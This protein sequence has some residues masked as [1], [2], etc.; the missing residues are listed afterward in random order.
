MQKRIYIVFLGMIAA[1]P[2]L[3][4]DM[5]LPAIPRIGGQWGV[6]QS[7][8]N[9]SLVL[10]FVAYSPTLLV[11]GSLSDRYGRRPILLSG[12]GAFVVSSLLCAMSGDVYQLIVARIFQGIAAAGASSMVM[13]IARDYFEG[14]ER[15]KVLAWIGIILGLAPMIAPSIGSAILKHGN[16]RIIFAV[17]AILATVSLSLTLA[18]YRETALVLDKDGPGSFFKRYARLSR[19]TR[20]VLANGTTGLLSAPFLG[21]VAF[22]ASA[23]IVHF[24]MSEQRFAILFGANAVFAIM[25]SAACTRVIRRYNEYRLITVT[26][27]GCLAAGTVL[28]ITGQAVWILFTLAMGV[29]SFF[30]GMS[31]PLINHLVLEQVDRDIGAA[32]SGIV[33]YQFIAGAC[34]MAIATYEWQ[35]PF[36]VFGVM[37]TVCPLVVLLTWPLLL[38]RIRRRPEDH[39]IDIESQEAGTKE[40]SA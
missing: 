34:G 30:F 4:T 15:Q 40:M 16:W 17:Q 18:I 38:K 7:T 14:K 23:Y 33:C 35:R 37:A 28:L 29:Y 2:P 6:A 21:F 32:A 19:N 20:Y 10:W 5:Y 12:L 22:S 39:T 31:R 27:L 24:G 9:L 13:A 1:T 3:A 26:Y 36:L 8:V 25:G 11:W